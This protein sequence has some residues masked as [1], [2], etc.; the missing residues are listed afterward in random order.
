M[1]TYLSDDW[2]A[3]VVWTELQVNQVVLLGEMIMEDQSSSNYRAQ[4][5]HKPFWHIHYKMYVEASFTETGT[6]C[7]PTCTGRRGQWLLGR[8]LYTLRE[9]VARQ[10]CHLSMTARNLSKVPG[11]HLLINIHV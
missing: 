11:G 6:D 4:S 9:I 3:A 8:Y 1:T 2:Q 10:Y 5:M 7:S